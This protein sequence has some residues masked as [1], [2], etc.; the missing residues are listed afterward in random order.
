MS[1]SPE[2][3]VTGG[4]RIYRIPLDLFP[5]LEGYAHLICSGGEVVLVDTGSGIGDSNDQL[6]AGL[7][8]VRQLFDEPVGWDRLTHVVVSH[9]HIDHFGGLPFVRTRTSAPVGVHRFDLKV[10]ADYEKRLEAMADRLRTF[11]ASADVPPEEIEGLM[12]LYLFT[13]NLYSS[14][15]IDFAFGP[16]ESDLGALRIL[17][18]PGHCPGQIVIAAGE[19]IFTSDHVLPDVTPHMAPG[20]LA[21]H[22]GLA[23]YLESLDRLERWHQGAGPALGGH[24]APMPDLRARIGAIRAHHQ[25]RLER[26]LAELEAPRTIA[27]L[28]D[29]VFPAAR[30]YHRLL[31]LEE[32][33]A[34][35]EYLVERHALDQDP[36]VASNGSVL[37]HRRAQGV[38]A[39]T[40]SDR[41]RSSPR[42]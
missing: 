25:Q 9:G 31:A 41:T 23:A 18:V 21:R 15:K 27:M 28:A 5:G 39:V 2:R 11:L 42:A 34:H 1:R 26:I 22:T 16:G 7:E 3:F 37:R 29:A 36:S 33:A 19:I 13:K 30:G 20:S 14:Q 10:L 6:E 8:G 38:S 17:H 4:T 24:G 35:V 40:A 12:D 32:V